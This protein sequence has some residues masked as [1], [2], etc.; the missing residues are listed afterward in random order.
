MNNPLKLQ[1]SAEEMGLVNNSEW[2]LT[3]HRIIKKVYEMF[4]EINEMM[5]KEVMDNGQLFPEN[6]KYRGGKISK[7]ENYQ[8]LPYVMLDYPSFFVKNNIFTVRTMFWWGNFFS[9]TLHLSGYHKTKFTNG[10]PKL[11]LFLKRNNFFICVNQE[12]WQHHFKE[13]NYVL[14][15]TITSGEY[16]RIMNQDF[17]KVAK[18]LSLI[19]WNNAYDFITESFREIL[20]LLQINFPGDKKDLLPGSPITG[21]GL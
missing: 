4:G 14:A 21:S 9:I 6:L 11:L 19:Q 13:E 7:G 1:L 15:A 5:K 17:F 18:K 10:N 16:N 8:M 12:E 3:K 20:E 2:I